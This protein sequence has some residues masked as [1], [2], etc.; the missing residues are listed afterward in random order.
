[1]GKSHDRLLSNL[2][3]WTFLL[4]Q[5]I[6]LSICMVLLKKTVLIFRL[7]FCSPNLPASPLFNSVPQAH[8]NVSQYLHPNTTTTCPAHSHTHMH[9]HSHMC[10]LTQA[11]THMH[12]NTP[13]LRPLP[14]NA[15][16][17]LECPIPLLDLINS[18][19]IFRT[20]VLGLLISLESQ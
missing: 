2:Q 19:Q 8:I 1:M 12:I 4:D 13:T 11:L 15:S 17:G 18:H 7:I 9:I 20:T 6:T 5:I 16:L 3:L 14:P 10:T